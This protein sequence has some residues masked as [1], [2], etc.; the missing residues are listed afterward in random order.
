MLTFKEF[1]E[2]RVVDP[3]ELGKRVSNLYGKRQS[4][5]KW[6]KAEKGKHI[7]LTNY[8]R[9]DVAS[10]ENKFD[11]VQSNLGFFNKDT[12]KEA[13]EK[14]KAMQTKQTLPIKDLHATQPFVRTDD[15]D[16]LKAKVDET[17]PSHIIVV[18]HKNKHYIM[19]GH[20]AV[21]AAKLRGDK[22]VEVHHVDLDSVK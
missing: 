18:K 9:K 20:H 19:D 3:T 7:P 8:N 15:E 22:T 4:Y 12:Q 11:R 17:N 10:L 1:L 21:M 13:Q 6:L 2:E 16:R 5:G 14:Y